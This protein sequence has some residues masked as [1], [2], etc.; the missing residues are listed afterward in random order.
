MQAQQRTTDRLQSQNK[1]VRPRMM[2]NP[3]KLPVMAVRLFI[4]HDCAFSASR[5]DPTAS[6]V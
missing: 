4:H 6:R 3:T 1:L 5:V 2:L